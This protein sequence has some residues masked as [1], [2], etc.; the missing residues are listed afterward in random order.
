M[1]KI[2]AIFILFFFAC[3]VFAVSS[4]NQYGQKEGSYNVNST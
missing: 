2:I 4:Y 3:P 1:K